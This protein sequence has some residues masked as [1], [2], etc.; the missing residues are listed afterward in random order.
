MRNPA[1][2]Q[3]LLTSRLLLQSLLT[4][5]LL[6]QGLLT[7]CLPPQSLLTSCRP[8][9]SLL[10][11][12]RPRLSPRPRWPPCLSLA[13]SWLSPKFL[14]KNFFWGGYSTQAPAD[15]EHGPGL[16]ASVMD[17]P[18]MSER[19]AGIPRASALAVT[20]T[21]RRSPFCAC[22]L[23][24]ALLRPLLPTSLLL[25]PLLSMS[26]LL[27]PL[28]STSLLLRPLLST[29]LLQRPL[30]FYI[31]AFSRRF[32][33][34]QLTVHSGYTCF[35]TMLQRPL[36]SMNLRQCLQ[37]WRLPLQNHQRWQ[38]PLQNLLRWWRPLWNSRSV[39][40]RP[41]RPSMNSRSVLSRPLR[42]LLC[43]LRHGSLF[44]HSFQAL[45]PLALDIFEKAASC[46]FPLFHKS[47]LRFVFYCECTQIK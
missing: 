43:L 22:G 23:H 24:T 32:Y 14:Q 6:I 31:Y 35:I 18:L 26:L 40:S 42:P 25:R 45:S 15:A 12:C 30:T 11:S 39:L 7:S 21:Q 10:M 27:R 46:L 47:R 29:S 9:Q 2:L 37:R 16:I 4:S 36:W 19:A 28:L 3:G 34:K 20:E 44:R 41:R 38:L 33:P 1:I 17:P 13:M 8:R 5:C